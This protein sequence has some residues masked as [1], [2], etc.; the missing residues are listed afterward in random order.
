MKRK[1]TFF[2]QQQFETNSLLSLNLPN[3]EPGDENSVE[4]RMVRVKAEW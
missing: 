1:Q 2:S 4:I 3:L